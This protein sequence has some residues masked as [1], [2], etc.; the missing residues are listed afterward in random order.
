MVIS[1]DLKNELKKKLYH[2]TVLP[3]NFSCIWSQ[4]IKYIP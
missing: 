4:Y 2:S 1:S 3:Y